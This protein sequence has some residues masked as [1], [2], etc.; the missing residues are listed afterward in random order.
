[1][2]YNINSTYYE[3]CELFKKLIIKT[4]KKYK[5]IFIKDIN[6]LINVKF[7]DNNRFKGSITIIPENNWID[8]K[9]NIM[10]KISD[11]E[12]ICLLCDNEHKIFISCNR[13]SQSC[14]LECYINMFRINKGIIKCSF[15][16]YKIYCECPDHMIDIYVERMVYNLLKEK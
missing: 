10:N 6:Y 15:C 9:R 12:K 1:M 13:C 3:R 5:F 2:I 7:Y 8:I 14:C 11:I 16:N 4:F